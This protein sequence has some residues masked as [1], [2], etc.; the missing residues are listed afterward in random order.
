[1]NVMIV[2][3]VLTMS[4]VSTC[5]VAMS[6]TVPKDSSETLPN[7]V[8]TL[9]NVTSQ[10]IVWDLAKSVLTHLVP[11]IA[12]VS[13]DSNEMIATEALLVWTL[14]NAKREPRTPVKTSKEASVSI[15]SLIRTQVSSADYS[16]L[17]I[18]FLRF[19]PML[20]KCKR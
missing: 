19:V 3:H 10:D 1:M 16:G 5:T 9:M 14:T 17:Y 7:S 2:Q 18:L 13:R 12:L 20:K 11:T 4:S 15:W 8:K 6:A